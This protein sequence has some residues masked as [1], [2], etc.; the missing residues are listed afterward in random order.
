VNETSAGVR[1]AII[2]AAD[3]VQGHGGP[4]EL[5]RLSAALPAALL[6]SG[7]A[8]IP[9]APEMPQNFDDGWPAVWLEGASSLNTTCY[10]LDLLS[11]FSSLPQR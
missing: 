1:A 7:Q 4:F 5:A 8:H 9:A 2:R 6:K 3:Y 10:L 11:D